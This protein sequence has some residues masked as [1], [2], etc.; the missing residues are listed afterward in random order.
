MASPAS[1]EVA[2]CRVQISCEDGEAMSG[3]PRSAAGAELAFS[4]QG[5]AM[6]KRVAG[7]AEAVE[8]DR[9]LD[10]VMIAGTRLWVR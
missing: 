1:S 7:F 8:V 4:Y 3:W 5:A 10:M 9:G 2:D 6:E